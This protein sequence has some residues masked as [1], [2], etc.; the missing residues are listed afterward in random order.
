MKAFQIKELKN[1]MTKLLATDIFDC[2][3]LA[4]ATITTYNTFVIDGHLVKDFFT[5]DI[6]DD[7]TLSLQE[8]SEWKD[9]RSLCFD[10]IKGKRTPVNF[11]FILHLKPALIKNI[12]KQGESA[13]SLSDI[14]SFVLNLKYDGSSLTCITGTAFHNFVPDKTPDRLWDEYVT[15]FFI[16]KE[17]SFEQAT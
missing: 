14:K 2:F 6:N 15:Q 5:G 12:L 11:K 10:L 3:L 7:T 13:L 9:M 4:E 1:F 8:F 17:I 16:E